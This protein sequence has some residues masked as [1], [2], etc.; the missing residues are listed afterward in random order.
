MALEVHEDL[1]KCICSGLERVDRILQNLITGTLL[2]SKVH[3]NLTINAGKL[4][5]IPDIAHVVKTISDPPIV[6]IPVIG[7]VALSQSRKDLFQRLRDTVDAFPD[8]HMLIVA[9]IK[10]RT[11]YRA[12]KP[13]SQAWRN[14]LSEEVARS[15]YT[16]IS[17]RT[18]PRSLERPTEIRVE[19]HS[20]C[21]ISS[22]H[23]QVWVR[24]SGPI[25]IDTSDQGLTAIGVGPVNISTS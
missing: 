8:V 2:H 6:T 19:G 25:D 10:E 7:E 4:K 18:G 23:F 13:R 12:P 14:L 21:S 24:G 16:F 15:E 1:I 17:N 11:T 5:F 9:F 20:W 3:T 22:V